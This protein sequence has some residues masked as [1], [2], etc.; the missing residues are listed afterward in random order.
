M[1]ITSPATAPRRLSPLP[2]FGSVIGRTC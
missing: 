2:W 1:A